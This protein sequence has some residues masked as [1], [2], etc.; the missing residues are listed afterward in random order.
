MADVVF[1]FFE[2]TRP[3][4]ARFAADSARAA[5]TVPSFDEL[6]T[7]RWDFDMGRDGEAGKV[8]RPLEQ[9]IAP[10]GSYRHA[11]AG[12]PFE[13][14]TLT[15]PM[16]FTI[17]YLPNAPVPGG[18]GMTQGPYSG[19][20]VAA[21]DRAQALVQFVTNMASERPS[22]QVVVTDA[23]DLSEDEARRAVAAGARLGRAEDQT[24]I[25]VVGVSPS[26]A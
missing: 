26:G 24:D 5:L 10:W 23:V 7:V 2:L 18:G 20:S 9:R 1:P 16:T 12:T 21:D 25:E 19:R 11:A 22:A 8:R 4:R 13:R 6:L 15:A 17:R 14:P 3:S